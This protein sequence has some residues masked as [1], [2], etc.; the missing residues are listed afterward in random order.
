MQKADGIFYAPEAV[1]VKVA[2]VKPGEFCFAAVGLDHGHI[3]AMTNGLKEAGATLKYV[4]D[5][6]SQKV[7]A[8]RKRY[9]EAKPATVEEIL[10]DPSVCMV[11]SAIRPDKRAGLGIQVME[12]GQKSI[13]ECVEIARESI[14]SG[15]ALATFK[16]F[17]E[18]NS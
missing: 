8:F 18:I 6:D 15:K 4:S 11:A 10:A 1:G 14:D 12:K 17:V 5:P 13:E 2:V 7:E 16:K 9:P 3:Y